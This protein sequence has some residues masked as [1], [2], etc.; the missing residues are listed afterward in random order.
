VLQHR[1]HDTDRAQ[2]GQG[3]AE[4]ALLLPVLLTILLGTLDLGRS[5][6]TYIAL[7]NAAREAARYA[8]VNDSSA[9][10]TQAQN[11]LNSGGSDISGCAS[12]TL[13]YS[14]SGGGGRGNA[15]TVNVSCQFTLVTPF[16]SAFLGATG[17][18]ITIHSTAT[19]VED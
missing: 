11:E 17:N 9:S 4:L 2:L 1:R 3:M 19:F 18:Q 13:T 14:A 10:I 8:A 7:T 16:V 12:G 5:F 6:Y 15:Y